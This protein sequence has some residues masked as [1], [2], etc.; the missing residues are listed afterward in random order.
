MDCEQYQEALSASALG[1]ESGAEVQAFRLHLE[2]CEA[3]RCELARRREFLG[4]LDRHLHTQFE[5]APSTDFNARLRRRIADE[6]RRSPSPSLRWIPVFAGAVALVVL[7]TVAYF[8]KLRNAEDAPAPPAPISAAVL[9]GR[10]QAG[11][12]ANDNDIDAGPRPA[13]HRRTEVRATF[14]LHE[15]GVVSRSPLPT[16]IRINPEE[17]RSLAPFARAVSRGQVETASLV[18]APPV[19]VEPLEAKALEFPPITFAP[20]ELRPTAPDR[21]D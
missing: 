5:A 4:S 2:I 17:S 8:R 6:P 14:A 20:L 18:A 10:P 16:E 7:L 9:E 15:V 19:I 1:A 12:S 11:V 3:C 21:R 13:T